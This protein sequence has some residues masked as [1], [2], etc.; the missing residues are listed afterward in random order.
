MR[1]MKM[2]Q[3]V[4][5]VSQAMKEIYNIVKKIAFF[6]TTVLIE[7]ETG[8][9][10]EV[11]ANLIHQSSPRANMPFIKVNCGAIPESLLESELFGYERGA[12]T[13]ANREGSLGLFESANK[14]SLLL[15]EVGQ[16]SQSLQ[17]KLLRVLQ[18]HEI[19]HIGGSWSKPIDVRIL[20]CTN[21][22][23]LEQVKK[24]LFRMDL[25]YRLNV[26]NIKIP[27]LRNRR[28]DIIP[29]IEYFLDYF[30]GEYGFK[31]KF[32]ESAL[33]FILNYNFS[34]NI[35]ELRNI[36][37]SSF[38]NSVNE[39]ISVDSL[40][41][42]IRNCTTSLSEEIVPNMDRGDV[43][44]PEFLDAIERQEIIKAISSSDSIRKAA[45]LLGI[46]NATMLRRIKYHDIKINR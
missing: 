7:G 46:N 11:I 25:Y 45:I 44:L 19:R 3:T 34:G 5:F 2:E 24:G 1:G 30:S 4:I 6:P 28:D 16:M 27:P 22:D 8:V 29:L 31:R 39:C 21:D 26:V 35:R 20:A 12:F 10:K 15:D 41:K 42:Y 18:D 43:P 9:G 14:G 13:G 38:I 32:E 36:V 33:S 40:P 23:L 37:E 17:V